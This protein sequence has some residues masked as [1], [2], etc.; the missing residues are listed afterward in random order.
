MRIGL[1]SDVAGGPEL[2]MWQVMRSAVETQQARAFADPDI[3]L[4]SPAEAFCLATAG[5]AA[6]LGKE[7]RIGSLEAGKEADL[8]VLD[9]NKVL[10]LDGRFTGELDEQEIL[11][12]LVYRGG[13][14]ATLATFVRG[15]QL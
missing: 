3:P 6:A 11:N 14:G 5:G 12:A 1:G 4:L 7:A 9:L 8:L 13:P 15:R 10:P 2:N